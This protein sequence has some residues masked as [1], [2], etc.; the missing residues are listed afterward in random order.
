[1][2]LCG[3]ILGFCL[4]VALTGFPAAPPIEVIAVGAVGGIVLS[5]TA[6]ALAGVIA[7][8]AT[9]RH[10]IVF[11][12]ASSALAAATSSATIVVR[13]WLRGRWRTGVIDGRMFFVAAVLLILIAAAGLSAAIVVTL[14]REA[15]RRRRARES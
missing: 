4:G 12:I 10:A 2:L 13:Q 8:M 1:V 5:M 15:A 7:A 3:V 14:T 11:T 6:G 9:P